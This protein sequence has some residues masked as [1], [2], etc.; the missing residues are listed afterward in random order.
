MRVMKLFN[1]FPRWLKFSGLAIFVA[2]CV[3]INAIAFVS[4]AR[5]L[6]SRPPA[7]KPIAKTTTLQIS[8]VQSAAT[9]NPAAQL[10]TQNSAASRLASDRQSSS[11]AQK[12]LS[13]SSA[14]EP[15]KPAKS[16]DSTTTAQTNQAQTN[17]AQTNQAQTSQAQTKTTPANDQS[18]AQLKY[19][20]RPY[21]ALDAA[22]LVQ[23]ASYPEGTSQRAEK[24]HPEA[25]AALL[26]M[27]A[28]ARADGIWLVPASGFR[29][30]AQQRTLF[31]T[32]V[33]KKG[34]PEAAAKI[35]APPGY[36]EHH[37]GYAIDLADGN[38]PQ[39]QDIS[40]AFANTPAYRWLVNN[41]ATYRFE[42][43]FPENNPQGV[44]FEPWHWRYVGSPQ[45]KATFGQSQLAET[46][47]GGTERLI[48]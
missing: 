21:A 7:S 23:V 33:A 17:Q 3:G 46:I 38:S 30:F 16:I 31:N 6:N 1:R 14:S 4:I 48:E 42:L 24:M 25:A 9:A 41:A 43:S 10:D 28:A 20:H 36:S 5:S 15:V 39:N 44:S 22:D 45:A 8:P 27:V 12:P 11:A 29:T 35:S 47:S 26:N 2:L 34:S 32:Q 40:P 13:N 19:G 18:S 37:T